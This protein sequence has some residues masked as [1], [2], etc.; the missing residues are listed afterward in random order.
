VLGPGD[1]GLSIAGNVAAWACNDGEIYACGTGGCANAPT[2][3]TDLGQSARAQSAVTDGTHVYFRNDT[4]VARC[5]I[6]GCAGAP[7]VLATYEGTTMSGTNMVLDGAYLYW[8][9]GN[10]IHRLRVK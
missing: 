9:W 3:V 4:V 2:V 10:E 7:E 8:G 6:A 5:P 1:V